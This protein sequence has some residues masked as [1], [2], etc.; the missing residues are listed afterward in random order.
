MTAHGWFLRPKVFPLMREGDMPSADPERMMRRV[1]GFLA[2]WLLFLVALPTAWVTPRASTDPQVWHL[3]VREGMRWWTP[4]TTM[5]TSA[6][7]VRT[8]AGHGE[9]GGAAVTLQL[10]KGHWGATEWRPGG[11]EAAEA[12]WCGGAWRVG[13]GAGDV[14]A[15]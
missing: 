5:V 4:A 9:R 1:W 13:Q 3:R 10:P 11:G 14:K 2:M 8:L 7:A 15:G 12:G 6:G